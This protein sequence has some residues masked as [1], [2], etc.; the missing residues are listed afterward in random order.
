MTVAVIGGSGF[1]RWDR[2]EPAATHNIE[3]PYAT[4]PVRVTEGT[5]AGQA[6]VFLPRHG[7]DHSLP[8]HLINYRANLWALKELDVAAVVAIATVGGIST[9]AAPGALMLPDQLLDY[10]YGRAQ[11][12]HDG[13]DGVVAHV[14]MTEPYCEALR[15]CLLEAAVGSGVPVIDG[16]TYAA[17]QGPRFETAA[18]IRR[19]E[20]D[21][22][23][24]VGMTGMPEAA[25]AKELQLAYA[26]IAIIVNP[27]AGKARGGISM[28]QV[29]GWQS[30]GR[31]RVEQ[32]LAH[33]VPAV[34]D[35]AFAVP[36]PLIA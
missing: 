21:G 20:R 8:P 23:D 1:H 12:F 32:L 31:A 33:A 18:E 35:Q 15:G 22:A 9:A 5:L 17:T 28:E 24:V 27:A 30:T 29:R 10:T 16:G 6:I 4:E 7:R 36:P 2:F 14:D 11:T 3:T 25:L 19:L 34:H 26:P 13:A